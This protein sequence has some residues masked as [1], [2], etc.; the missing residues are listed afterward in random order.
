MNDKLKHPIGKFE[1][2]DQ[3]KFKQLE[4][5]IQTIAKFPQKLRNI[6][7]GLNPSDLKKQYRPEGWSIAQV[8]HHLADSHMHCY[9][10]M[11]H[12]VLENEPN[13]KDYNQE[14]WATL[15]DAINIEVEYSLDLI[16]ALHKRWSI[17]LK[18]LNEQEFK[19]C[20]FH[21]ERN[22][23]YP[24]GTT[25]LLYAWHCNHHLAHIENSLKN[26]Y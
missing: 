6:L 20:Y 10:R 11:K 3:P 8:V 16:E 5:A 18:G 4:K 22:K 23:Q 25:T 15:S 1:W 24:I 14:N 17:F 2:I 13:I 9:L 19:R 21:P 26:S 7:D 12:A